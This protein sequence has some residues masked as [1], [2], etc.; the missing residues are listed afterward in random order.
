MSVLRRGGVALLVVVALGGSAAGSASAAPRMWRKEPSASVAVHDHDNKLFGVD[1]VRSDW[2][3]AVGSALDVHS[4]NSQAVIEHWDGGTWSL[5]APAETGTSDQLRAVT[6]LAVDDCTA[7]GAAGNSTLVEH[8][9]G[10]SWTVVPSPDD[11]TYNQLESVAC[12]TASNCFAAGDTFDT[13]EP[14]ALLEQWDGAH[15][16][17]VPSL[18]PDASSQLSGVSC[19]SATMCFAVGDAYRGIQRTITLTELWNGASWS[20]VKSPNL[21]TTSKHAID[22]LTDVACSS[23]TACTAVGYLE[24]SWTSSTTLAERWNGKVW[25]LVSTPAVPN[26]SAF[27]GI[28]CVGTYC[29]AVGSSGSGPNGS[30]TLVETTHGRDFSVV[31][32]ASPGAG[33][34]LLFG[35]ACSAAGACKAVGSWGGYTAPPW[36]R[37]LVLS[38]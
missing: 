20:I 38:P 9:N 15:W 7:V 13:T 16:T 5:A 34:N 14:T 31:G 6:C 27:D 26:A 3:V 36:E 28:D 30:S 29:A 18:T 2:C 33:Y 23:P 21:P 1:C 32:S 10:V 24:E 8:W 12:S 37:T 35:V 17:V 11:R 22:T 19:P 4:A 25:R